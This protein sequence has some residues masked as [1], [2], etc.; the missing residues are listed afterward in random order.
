MD[1][2][3]IINNKEFKKIWYYAPHI[4]GTYS[5]YFEAG[6]YEEDK[7]VYLTDGFG[8]LFNFCGGEITLMQ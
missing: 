8:T 1:G 6:I 2:D 7:K 5:L 4:D 3:T